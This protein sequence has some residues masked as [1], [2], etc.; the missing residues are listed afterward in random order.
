MHL[1]SASQRM[2]CLFSLVIFLCAFTSGVISHDPK[3]PTCCRKL[4]NKEP[5]VKITSCY[6]LPATRKCLAAVVFLDK[7]N[8]LHCINPEAPWLSE[9]IKRLEQNGVTCEDYTK[10]KDKD[11]VAKHV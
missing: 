9:R 1:S 6:I 5:V 11:M 4:T 7:N 3:K 10:S 8:R 2:F